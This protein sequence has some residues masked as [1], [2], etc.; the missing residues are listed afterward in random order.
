M[1]AAEYCLPLVRVGGLFVAA[2]GSDPQMG[3][4]PLFQWGRGPKVEEKLAEPLF[5]C[6]FGFS[7]EILGGSSTVCKL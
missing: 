7:I 6:P 1:F 3:Q 5:D 2:K 4:S